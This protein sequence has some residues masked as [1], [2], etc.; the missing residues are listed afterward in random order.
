MRAL[1]TNELHTGR[2]IYGVSVFSRKV[3][4]YRVMSNP[5]IMHYHTPTL[6]PFAC[7]AT[8]KEI[9]DHCQTNWEII[10]SNALYGAKSTSPIVMT[11]KLCATMTM[12]LKDLDT[13]FTYDA[14]LVSD[15]KFYRREA[16]A[17]KASLVVKDVS[18]NGFLRDE[19]RRLSA[20]HIDIN[21]EESFAMK[22]EYAFAN[23]HILRKPDYTHYY[24]VESPF[25]DTAEV[26]AASEIDK[27]VKQ[28]QPHKISIVSDENHL[29]F[30]PG[31]YKP[32]CELS[33]DEDD[34]KRISISPLYGRTPNDFEGDSITYKRVD[35]K[36][37]ISE[38]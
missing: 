38:E 37:T 31:K 35:G 11:R 23:S 26:L 4:A 2:I 32:L 24:D 29:S 1:R 3:Y 33:L 8:A 30:T 27:L 16:D 28:Q 20:K 13:E 14:H 10:D 36:L 5:R 25:D 17:I 12:S 18:Y 21:F 34:N 6:K 22:S 19:Q 9:Y 15:C 7:D